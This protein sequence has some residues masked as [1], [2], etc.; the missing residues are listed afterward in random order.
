MRGR[1]SAN[2]LDDERA[3]IL[4]VMRLPNGPRET[5][6]GLAPYSYY[7]REYETTG[8]I[9]HY[10]PITIEAEDGG[11]SG[12]AA[13]DDAGIGGPGMDSD[14]AAGCAVGASRDRGAG[15]LFLLLLLALPPARRR[16]G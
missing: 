5:P 10:G 1:Y 13:G 16:Q 15:A 7:L 11:E 6:G 9:N 2:G 8:Q 12:G 3:A 4:D 14:P